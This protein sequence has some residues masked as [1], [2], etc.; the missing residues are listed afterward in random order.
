L[1]PTYT[2]PR[3]AAICGAR[4]GRDT[5]PAT[6]TRR[7]DE[8]AKLDLAIVYEGGHTAL[9]DLPSEL[10]RRNPDI[11]VG[12]YRQAMR[13]PEKT[14]PTPGNLAQDWI[15]HDAALNT[16]PQEVP[17]WPGWLVMDLRRPEVV[18]LCVRA[19]NDQ[20]ARLRPD[21][22]L[23]DEAHRTIR[24]E[25]GLEDVDDEQ[26]TMGVRNLLRRCRGG[27][28]NGNFGWPEKEPEKYGP[29]DL[30]ETWT[31]MLRGRMWQ[32]FENPAN[33]GN[34]KIVTFGV[35]ECRLTQPEQRHFIVHTFDRARAFEAMAL[36]L[37]FDGYSGVTALDFKQETVP[38]PMAPG[39]LGRPLEY[40]E[41]RSQVP[42]VTEGRGLIVRYF[43]RG[44]VRLHV[45]T[46]DV[47][48]DI[49]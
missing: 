32:P 22:I 20:T 29:D 18:D 48:V 4:I 35:R 7:L 46:G 9:P 43:E 42:V 15:R 8:W 14:R 38:F 10:R 13:V 41:G 44:T 2:F 17:G 47:A 19:Y 25:A 21:M 36:S 39:I 45:D 16:I 1:T 26:W 23:W 31:S 12:L 5:D 34:V 37:F 28:V 40:A 11:V 49:R 33:G 30:G 6:S 27:C 3:Y 24:F